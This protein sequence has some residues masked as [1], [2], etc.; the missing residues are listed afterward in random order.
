[1]KTKVFSPAVA[2]LILFALGFAER[3]FLEGMD[4]AEIKEAVRLALD[5]IRDTVTVLSDDNPRNDEQVADVW[6]H[7]VANDVYAY[8]NE[9]I[10]Q[11]L[12]KIK[13]E[14][15]RDTLIYISVPIMKM[16]QMAF[17][18][19]PNNETQIKQLW[20]DFIQQPETYEVIVKSLLIPALENKFEDN[21][22]VQFIIDFLEDALNETN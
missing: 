3:R 15:F 8:G 20:T 7:F 13:D 10:P 5:P 12:S 19:N 22:T 1:M 16:L 14:N 2:R 11:L 17:D 18:D 6:K 21:E 4:D 9:N